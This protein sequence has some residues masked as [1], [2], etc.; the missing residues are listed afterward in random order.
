[1]IVTALPDDQKSRYYLA[2]AYEQN[3]QFE[4]ALYHFRM[5]PEG[6]ELYVN[7]RLHTAYLFKQNGKDR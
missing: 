3:N 1:M 4:E 6:N 2:L 5:I 7:A